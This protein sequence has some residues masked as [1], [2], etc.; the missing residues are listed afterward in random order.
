MRRLAGIV[1]GVTLVLAAHAHAATPVP[2]CFGA[3]ARDPRHP[4][5]NP[6]LR[7][8]VTPTPDEALLNPS[9]ACTPQ[10]I[11]D[12]LVQC[13]FGAREAVASV[14][15]IGDSHAQHWRS[16]LDVVAAR[17]HWRVYDLSV[18]LCMFSTAGPGDPFTSGCRHWNQDVLAWL[19]AHPE[20]HVLFVAGKAL[21]S[22]VAARG[23][24]GYR[25]RVNGYVQRWAQLPPSVRSLIV[26]HD[27]PRERVTTHD[28]VRHALARH[29]PVAGACGV[30]RRWALPRDPAVAAAG[31]LRA[32]GVRSIDLTPQFC[33]AR[34]CYPVIGGALVHKD[35]DHLTQVFSRTLGPFLDR[36]LDHD[37]L[38]GAVPVGVARSSP[39]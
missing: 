4:C 9:F 14:A 39:G 17:R 16:A 8:T 27:P 13:S 24:T 10:R 21:E 31:R 6:H 38:P 33:G 5:A 25:T 20:V 12:A 19:G 37:S 1:L 3:A 29:R 18:P 36:A 2:R 23:E 15:L 34:L 30:P 28:C 7:L 35:T 11:T 26:I 22:V 32:R